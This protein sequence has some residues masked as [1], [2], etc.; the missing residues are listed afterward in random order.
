MRDR[1]F[2]VIVSPSGDAVRHQLR[3]EEY[4]Y[5]ANLQTETGSIPLSFKVMSGDHGVVVA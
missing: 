4:V 3:S 1:S 2:P 5:L